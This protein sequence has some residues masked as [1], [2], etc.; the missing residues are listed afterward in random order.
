MPISVLVVDDHSVFADAM[1]SRLLAEPDFHPVFVAYS[2][3]EAR[4]MLSRVQVDVAV[5]DQGLG[6]GQGTQLAEHIRTGMPEARVIILSALRALE[7]VVDAVVVGVSGW[8]PKTSDVSHLIRAIRGV[9]AGE[10]WMAPDLLGEV[11]PRLL[12]R[13]GDQPPDPLAVLTARE[14]QVLDCM[15]EGLSRPEISARLQLSGN[16]VRTH[17]QNLIGKLGVHSSLA[18]VAIALRSRS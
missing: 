9:H 6:D 3:A 15:V 10:I 13:L 7:P 16:T 4:T 1:Q 2:V 11:I 8:I 14:R 17:T 18:A 12:R 5:L